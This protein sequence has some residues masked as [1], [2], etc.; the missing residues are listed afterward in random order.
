MFFHIL[1]PSQTRSLFA[2][3]PLGRP[4][5]LFP[6]QLN[7]VP[8]WKQLILAIAT[9][10]KILTVAQTSSELAKATQPNNGDKKILVSWTMIVATT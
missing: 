10:R 2:V 5:C 7:S 1:V 6:N 3:E 4:L 9:N 8:N